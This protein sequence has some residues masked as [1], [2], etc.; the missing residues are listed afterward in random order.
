MDGC[1]GGFLE[2]W[3]G[4]SEVINILS[5]NYCIVN[6]IVAMPSFQVLIHV[7]L[8]MTV[9]IFVSIVMTPSSAN[10]RWDTF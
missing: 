7:P 6:F 3:R 5:F 8:D 4:G 2:T 9:S 1:D 10:V